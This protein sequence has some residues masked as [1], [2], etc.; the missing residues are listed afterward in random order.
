M[1]SSQQL[2][3]S[4]ARASAPGGIGNIGPGLDVLGCAVDG[5]R[6]AVTVAWCDADGLVVRDAGHPELPTDAARHSSA[7]AASAV[8]RR[9]R[10]AG[11]SM[12]ATGVALSLEKRL[13][14]SGGQ[15]GSAASAVAGAVAMHALL[16]G[17]LDERALLECCLEAEAAVA[18]RHLDNVVPILR[19]GIALVRDAE[20]MDVLRLPTPP[21]LHFVLVHPDMR[22]RTADAR[23]VLP[24]DVPRATALHQMAATAAMVAACYEGDV[25]AFGRAVDDRI[26]EP[27]RAALLPGFAD[28]KRAA[29]EA[30]AFGASISGAGPT[31]FAVVDDAA[32][33]ARVAEAARAAYERTGLASR[34]RVARV[35]EQGATVEASA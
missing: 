15:G 24:A 2:A 9:A 7:L 26:A 23:R 1:A 27:A 5:P 20:R 25:A 21:G 22:L 17:P 13:P 31:L 12:P 11:V 29:L 30:G 28:A 8:L 18:G 10:A 4:S 16:G 33:G 19:G 3:A 34:A 14:L 35:D 6:D 32:V